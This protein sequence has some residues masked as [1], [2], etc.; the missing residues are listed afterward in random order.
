MQ[1][2]VVFPQI[3]IGVD[4][5]AVRD[6]AQATESLGYDHLAVFEHVLGANAGSR[7][8]WTGPYRHTHMFHEPF[9]LLGY[10]ASVTSKVGF[11]TSVLVLPQRQTALVAKQAAAVDVLSGGRLR[12]GVGVGWNDVEFEALDEDFSNRGRRL[13]EQ[14]EVLRLLWTQELVTYEGR[15]HTIT[16]AGI[17]PLPVQRPIPLWMG[18]GAERV[19]RRIGRL[20]DGWFANTSARTA[21]HT[22]VPPLRADDGGR[23][24]LARIHQYATE[25]GRDPSEIGVEC[26]IEM[27]DRSPEDAAADVAMWKAMGVTHVQFTTLRAG[28]RSVDAHIDALQR[29]IDAVPK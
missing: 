1:I 28:L 8:G 25:A 26:R 15:W 20:A 21:Q 29:F 4:P 16:D 6:F 22:D 14:V 7:P 17:N 18:G 2:G 3:E 13:E 24:T 19:L 9:V 23:A 11:A 27:V 10:L 5:V 12:L